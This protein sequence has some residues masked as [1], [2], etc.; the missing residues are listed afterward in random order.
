MSESKKPRGWGAF[1]TLAR[2]L[3]AVPKEA[4]DAKVASDKAKRIKQRRKKKK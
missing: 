3:V 2:K 4:V 1:D